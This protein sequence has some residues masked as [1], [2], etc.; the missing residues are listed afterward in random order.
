MYADHSFLHSL[1][2]CCRYLPAQCSA[3]P[4]LHDSPTSICRVCSVLLLFLH[5]PLVSSVI[6]RIRSR[7]FIGYIACRPVI[8]PILLSPLPDVVLLSHHHRP[9]PSFN[10][11]LFRHTSLHL[12]HRH[13][14]YFPVYSSVA[15]TSVLDTG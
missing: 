12:K 9:T 2:R 1:R 6:L 10:A 4:S 11:R 8:H 14:I 5:I 3:N 13:I 7:S 15:F